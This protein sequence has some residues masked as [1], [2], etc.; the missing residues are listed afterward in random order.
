M[1]SEWGEVSA[2]TVAK[3]TATQAAG[4]QVVAVGTTATRALE[5][6]AKACGVAEGGQLR[7]WSGETNIFIYPSYRFVLVDRLM[8]N[9]HL[10]ESTLL[11]LVSALASRERIMAAYQHAIAAEYR[12][13]SYGDAMLIDRC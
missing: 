4:G 12:F 2:E 8:T 5:S 3:I 1:H 10:P 9:F 6:A 11:M 13:F 7:A